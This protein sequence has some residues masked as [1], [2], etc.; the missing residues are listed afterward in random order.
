MGMT[1]RFVSW[2]LEWAAS[3]ERRR[4]Q[5]ELIRDLAPDLLAV[6][7]VKATTLHPLEELFAWKVFALGPNPN[8]RYWKARFGTAVLGGTRANLRGQM[9][10]APTWFGL[11]DELNWKANRFARRAT[12]ARVQLEGSTRDILVGSLHA[13]P[14]AGPIGAHK[15]WF[16]GRIA[17]WLAEAEEPWLFGIDANAPGAEGSDIARTRWGWP[18]T[19]ARPG[20]DELLGA[21]VAHR[22]RDLL[23]DALDEDPA[24]LAR[25][26]AARP[27][28]PLAVSYQLGA[29]PVRYDH[30][31]AT[32]EFSVRRIEYIQ[33]GFRFSDHAPIV[34]DLE[35]APGPRPR[36]EP[37]LRPRVEVTA[38]AVPRPVIAPATDN[39]DIAEIIRIVLA[40]VTPGT[41]D[42]RDE[43]DP[44][45]RSQFRAGWR[46]H[47]VRGRTYS[48]RALRQLT[49][50]NLG[51]RVAR[52]VGSDG[53]D[54]A[55]I[56]AYL[57]VAEHGYRDRSLVL[58]E[59][60]H[61][62]EQ[63]LA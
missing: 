26:M 54:H 46:S 1:F 2:N 60:D 17:Q 57:A 19:A 30:C 51:Y 56:D 41:R 63:G 8:D 35:V 40:G 20:E 18:R 28:G 58:D 61:P 7:E 33:D 3:R 13:S 39:G 31:W 21:D 24:E 45:R 29:G 38:E 42:V 11:D 32:P 52:A 59:L 22:G 6:Q 25:I 4:G 37:T 16:H 10:V 49:W 44:A 36:P 53:A 48:A 14:A 27:D 34:C 5:L 9:L 62:T 47:S 55:L 15:P 12:W 50:N 23:R 43:P